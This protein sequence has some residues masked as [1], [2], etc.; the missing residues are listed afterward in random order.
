[1][2]ESKTMPFSNQEVTFMKEA[3]EEVKWRYN[4]VIH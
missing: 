3:L 2:V 1:M 4:I